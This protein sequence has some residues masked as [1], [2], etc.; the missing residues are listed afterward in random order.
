MKFNF[1]IDKLELHID[2]T[3]LMIAENLLA[4]NSLK[5]LKE[6]EKNLFL[7]HYTEGSLSTKKIE[8]EIQLIASK[9]KMASCECE[10]FMQNGVCA[11]IAAS[12]VQLNEN[13]KT[14]EA[15]KKEIKAQ[16]L[17]TS[18]PTRLTIPNILKTIEDKQLIEFIADYARSDKQF[19][20]A[21]KTRFAGDLAA[22]GDIAEHYKALIDST[23]KNAKNQKGKF[24][25]K[26][27]LQVFTL[28]DELRQ[29]AEARFRNGELPVSF[30][31]IS[32]V[33]PLIH[34]FMRPSDAPKIKLEK[35]QVQLVEI[36][37][38]YSEL[39]ISPELDTEM[40]EFMC[41]E[42]TQCV[43][44]PFSERL[45]DWLF[46]QAKTTE[47][48]EKLL[49]LLDHQLHINRSFLEAKDRLLTQKI[50]ILQKSGR[51]EEASQLILSA[52]EQPDVLYFAI[53]NAF[54]N[55]D[56]TLA[57]SL[58]RNGIA[59]FGNSNTAVEQIEGLLLDIAEAEYNRVDILDYA[60][61][62]FYK[63]LNLQYFEKMKTVGLSANN[64]KTI[65]ETLENQPLRLERRDALAAI[66]ASEKLFDKLTALIT[67]VQSL[68]LLRRYGVDLWRHDTEGSIDL[69]KKIIYEYLMSHLGRPPAQRIRQ[70]LEKHIA[71]GGYELAVKLRQDFNRDF[72]ER[73]SLIEEL[74]EMME[75]FEKKKALGMAF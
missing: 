41:H 50:Q 4:E 30:A 73:H 36:L 17:E 29:K 71:N 25:P 6:V 8:T 7:A 13:R 35:R 54:A 43:R 46:K 60:E 48:T 63:T 1:P 57:K 12:L 3:L 75:E 27:W 9:V 5:S 28:L 26:G 39:P 10:A 55:R 33:L 47:K 31:L 66:Y 20:L 51:V 52:S 44:H 59:I 67:Q 22:T 24:T 37:R 49:A 11:H 74:A 45:F 40:W 61:K 62:R 53:E 56:F 21:L 15:A 68:D 16:I 65:L 72:P 19:A 32:I 70:V 14:K 34:K 69:H 2:D 64:L 18:T 42:W 38:G 58:C 23:L